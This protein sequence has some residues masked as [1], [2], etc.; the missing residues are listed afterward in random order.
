[1]SVSQIRRCTSVLVRNAYKTGYKEI[2]S[3]I[4]SS[5]PNLGS[6]KQ[7]QVF[8]EVACWPNPK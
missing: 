2:D 7:N 5:T 4:K 6:Q 3:R 1:M 8:G